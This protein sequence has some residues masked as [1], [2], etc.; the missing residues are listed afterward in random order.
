[1]L[2]QRERKQGFDAGLLYGRT[3]PSGGDGDMAN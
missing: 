2:Y 3:L 1:M